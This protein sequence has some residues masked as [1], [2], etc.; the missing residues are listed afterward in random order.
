[1][2]GRSCLLVLAL[3][4]AVGLGAVPESGADGGADEWNQWRGPYR[5]GRVGAGAAP[6]PDGLGEDRL[7]PLWRVDLQPSYSGPVVAGDLVITTETRD[8]EFEVVTA[9]DRDSGEVR[10]EASW[11]GVMRVPFFARANGS[12]IRATPA[13]DGPGDRLLVAGMRDVLVCLRASTGEELWRIDFVDRFETPVPSFGFVSSPL[14]DGDVA[15]VQA[16]ASLA[17]VRMS[18]GEVEWRA[19]EDGGGMHG[20]A[21]SSPVIETLAGRRQLLVQGRET[22]AGLAPDT[23]DVLWSREVPSFRGMN[24]L[25]PLVLGDRVFTASYRHRAWAFEVSGA[26]GSFHSDTAWEVNAA[27]YMSSPVEID[28]HAYLHLQNQRFTCIDLATGEQRWTSDRFGKYVSL[29]SQGNRI[30]ALDERGELL[31]IEA[32]PDEFRL[33]GRRR[34]SDDECWAHLAVCGDRVYVRDLRA[35]TAWRWAE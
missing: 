33:L 32:N 10:W 30:L 35:L 14:I 17:R 24:I 9:L 31:L 34:V 28:G 27:G 25:T 26:D 5:D 11:E 21:F 16:G 3:A 13:H 20:S 15:Y 29:V 2:C 12:W 1:M 8:Q 19:M 6:W 22:L 18:D 7:Q 23:G 4:L